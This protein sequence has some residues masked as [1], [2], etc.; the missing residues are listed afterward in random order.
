VTA[1]IYGTPPYDARGAKDTPNAGDGIAVAN[2][3]PLA[4]AT[5]DASSG[6]VA[7]VAVTVA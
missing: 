1:E 3:A 4:M 7:M 6:F 5:G 2:L